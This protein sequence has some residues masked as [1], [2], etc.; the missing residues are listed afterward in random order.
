MVLPIRGIL[1]CCHKVDSRMAVLGAGDWLWLGLELWQDRSM[2][3]PS[4]T[5]KAMTNSTA[6]PLADSCGRVLA[7]T[8]S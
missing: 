8:R 3:V 6:L 2:V 1:N 7:W 4:A 5:E